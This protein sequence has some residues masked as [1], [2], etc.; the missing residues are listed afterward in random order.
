MEKKF[1][2]A[3]ELLKDAEHERY[4]TF[5]VQAAFVAVLSAPGIAE[6]WA[7]LGVVCAMGD[8]VEWAVGAFAIARLTA[9]GHDKLYERFWVAYRQGPVQERLQTLWARG[10]VTAATLGGPGYDRETQAIA[11]RSLPDLL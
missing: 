6:Y 9:P 2:H 7:L 10:A 5:A 11:E 1:D 3:T 8:R 4:R